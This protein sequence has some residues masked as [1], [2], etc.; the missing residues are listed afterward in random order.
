M[1]MPISGKVFSVDA[2]K[3]KPLILLYL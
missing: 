2:R 1:L 3:R